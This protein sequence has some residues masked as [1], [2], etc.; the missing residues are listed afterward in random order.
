MTKKTEYTCKK[1]GKPTDILYAVDGYGVCEK[2][3]KKNEIKRKTLKRVQ[4]IV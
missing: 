4:E 3:Y 1:C 2:C